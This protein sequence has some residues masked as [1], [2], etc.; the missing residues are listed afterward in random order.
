MEERGEWERVRGRGEESESMRRCVHQR[1]REGARGGSEGREGGEGGRDGGREGG[2]EREREGGREGGREEG[3][4]I[5]STYFRL[6]TWQETCACFTCTR[7]ASLRIQ[8]ERERERERERVL[9]IENTYYR[10]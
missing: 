7:R 1:Q 5:E 4:S 9:S 3:L 2:R 8:R 10:L 6:Y